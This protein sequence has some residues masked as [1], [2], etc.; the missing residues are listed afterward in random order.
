M[1]AAWGRIGAKTQ[2]GFKSFETLKNITK[3]CQNTRISAEQFRIEFI[4]LEFK[5]PNSKPF[6]MAIMYQPGNNTLWRDN[7]N[8]VLDMADNEHKEII[9]L[10]DLNTNFQVR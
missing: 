8:Y 2:K 5:H 10:G 4:S 3:C 7:L 1:I 6:L 9:I